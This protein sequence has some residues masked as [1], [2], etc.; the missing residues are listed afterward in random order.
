MLLLTGG[1]SGAG[2]CRPRRTRGCWG[3]FSNRSACA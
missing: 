3:S 1:A 2:L